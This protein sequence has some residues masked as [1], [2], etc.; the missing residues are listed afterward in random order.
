MK[1]QLLKIVFLLITLGCMSGLAS[2]HAQTSYGVKAQV[3]FDFYVGDQLFE[4]GA[5]KAQASWPADGP[6]LISNAANQQFKLR[7]AVRMQANGRSEVAKLVFRRYENRYY[8]SQ[9]WISG[10][11]GRELVQS[12]SER[13]LARERRGLAKNVS[14]PEIVT[15][16][17]G[18]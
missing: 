15:I 8:L 18:R 4:A 5:I 12:S 16:V 2:V 11:E 3:P 1:K 7:P 6:I 13:A 10:S 17:A 9:V 14:E